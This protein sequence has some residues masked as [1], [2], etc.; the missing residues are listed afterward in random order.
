[1]T[2][3]PGQGKL[4]CPTRFRMKCRLRRCLKADHH[5]N[6]VACQVPNHGPKRRPFT[7]EDAHEKS[8]RFSCAPRLTHNRDL[9][10]WA[11]LGFRS[12]F[13]TR[14]RDQL[15][16]PQATISLQYDE[17]SRFSILQPRV[18]TQVCGGRGFPVGHQ[19]RPAGRP[20]AGES[21]RPF[22]APAARPCAAFQL[23]RR[24][25]RR[26]ETLSPQLA[27]ST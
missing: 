13:I 24:S 4:V 12:P 7:N 14:G 19:A 27:G 25:G 1:V 15:N 22:R 26:R 9:G 11:L 6:R 3:A 17:H 20:S 8:S 2:L 23:A 18:V 10:S 21:Y 16:Q 5:A